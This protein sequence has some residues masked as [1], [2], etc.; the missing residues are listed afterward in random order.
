[1]GGDIR[2]TARVAVD[3]TRIRHI[4][5]KVDGYVEKLFVDFVGMPVAKGEPLFTFFS[6]D[7][8]S[9]QEDYL[10]ALKIQK[11]L[12]GDPWPAA[13][14]TCWTPPGAA[15]RCGTCPPAS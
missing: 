3:E 8:V 11:S 10:L 2:T 14:P 1:M 9:A 13:A 6:P 5:V 15:W 12:A 7:F 4:H